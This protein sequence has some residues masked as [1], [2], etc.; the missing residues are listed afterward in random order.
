MSRKYS[1]ISVLNFLI[2]ILFFPKTR[3]IKQNR[4]SLEALL[5]EVRLN[6]RTM[7]ELQSYNDSK[8]TVIYKHFLNRSPAVAHT[9]V[10]S[11]GESV[12]TYAGNI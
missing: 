1:Q 6:I 7:K 2:V 11:F 8:K 10:D 4:N 3:Q 9:S 12:Y 5:L